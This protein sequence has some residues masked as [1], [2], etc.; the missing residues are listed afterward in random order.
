MAELHCNIYAH[1]KS[2]GI[3]QHLKA[4]FEALDANDAPGAIAAGER[5]D[6]EQGAALTENFLASYETHYEDLCSESVWQRDNYM[7]MHL[8]QGS[9]GDYLTGRL[10]KY[11]GQLLQDGTALAWGC[12]DDD[13]WEFWFKWHKGAVIRSDG[14]PFE[15]AAD[16]HRSK[17]TLYRWWHEGLPEW[18]VEGYLNE[19]VDDEG[20]DEDD[21]GQDVDDLDLDLVDLSEEEYQAWVQGL[22]KGARPTKGGAQPGVTESP[23]S[24]AEVSELIGSLANIFG[25]LFSHKKAAEIPETHY[26]TLDRASVEQATQEILN[27][28]TNRNKDEVLKHVSKNLRGES[29]ILEQ[30]EAVAVPSNFAFYKMGIEAMMKESFAFELI[31]SDWAVSEE[32]AE[33]IATSTSSKVRYKDPETD[34]LTESESIERSV[35]KLE[36]GK[37]KI[38]EIYSQELSI[39]PI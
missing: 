18:L 23:I 35:W 1:H 9:G 13:P 11:L 2:P 6:G 19:D 34:E 28:L 14:Q 29:K 32:L 31:K 25:P 12:G 22:V 7:C 26:T 17:Q 27:A 20:Q 38:V 4:L 15:D 30:G 10:V 36:Q 3:Q 39:K 37:L 21:E 16:D 5:M 24:N 8:V 33:T